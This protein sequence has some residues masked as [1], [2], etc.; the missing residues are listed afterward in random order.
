[1]KVRECSPADEAFQSIKKRLYKDVPWKTVPDP[2]AENLETCFVVT[3]NGETLCRAA[4]FT[5]DGINLE[6]KKYATVGSFESLEKS[7]AIQL[8]MEAMSAKAKQLGFDGIIGP[9]NGSTWHTYRFN[10]EAYTP[11]F[12]EFY[13]PAYYP[14]LWQKAGFEKLAGYFSSIAQN[15]QDRPTLQWEVPEGITAADN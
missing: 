10:A 7:E 4:L 15:L 1:M 13:H 6:G 11:F 14:E 8:L 3:R 5:G 12:T 2:I 9:M